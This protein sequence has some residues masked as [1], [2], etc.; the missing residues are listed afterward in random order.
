VLP[1][2]YFGHYN[3]G[4]SRVDFVDMVRPRFINRTEHLPVDLRT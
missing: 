4:I 2:V 3:T 1:G